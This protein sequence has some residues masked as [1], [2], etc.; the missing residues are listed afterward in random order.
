VIADLS[1]IA[2]DSCSVINRCSECVTLAHCGFCYRSDQ[3]HLTAQCLPTNP[4]NAFQSQVGS[5]CDNGTTDQWVWS[6]TWCPSLYPWITLFGLCFYLF[7]FAPGM[8]PM[9]WTINAELYP[10]WARSTCTSI[11]TSVN[12]LFN[13]LTSLTFLTITELL[14]AYGTFWLFFGFGTV[15]WFVFYVYLPETKDKSMEEETCKSDDVPVMLA[16]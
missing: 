8:G 6:S 12:W 5:A 2:N 3:M 13:L 16:H 4:S 10:L 1:P 9:P 15:G 11:T 7:S 14:G